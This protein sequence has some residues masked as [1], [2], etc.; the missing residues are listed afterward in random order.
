MTAPQTVILAE[1]IHTL[2]EGRAATALGITDGLITHVGSRQDAA[3]W[4]GPGTEVIDHGGATITPGLVDAHIHPVFGQ[5]VARGIFLGDANTL[6]EAAALVAGAAGGTPEPEV[7]L[8]YGLNQAVFGNAEPH[9]NWLEAAAP[10]RKCYITCFDAHSAMASPAMLRA[11]GVTGTERFDD[12]STV[13]LSA[14]GQPTGFLR[15]FGAMQLIESALPELSLD[16]KVDGVYQLLRGMAAA[17]LTGGEMLDFAD[18]DSLEIF[19]LIERRGEL[20]IKLRIAPWIMASDGLAAIERVRDMQG[21][22]GRRWHV[23]G[24]KLM[25]DGTVDNGTAWLYEPDTEGECTESLYMDP[26][27]YRRNLQQLAQSG[28]TTTTHAIGDQGI[29]FVIQAISELPSNGLAHRIEHLEEINDEDMEALAGSGATVSMQPS[30]CTHFVRAD[31]SDAW[32]RRLGE[33]RAS[34]AFRLRDVKDAGLVLALGSDWPVAPYDPRRI[35]AD[36]QTRRRTEVSGSDS[37][38]PRHKLTAR[39]ALEGYTVNV[40]ASSGIEGGRLAPGAPADLTVFA[41]DPLAISPEELCDVP[42]VATYIE[43]Q[44]VDTAAQLPSARV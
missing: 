34:F 9:G 31:G 8:G 22:Q 40:Y 43:G 6:E 13:A 17:G 3:A 28:V 25:I 36:A 20:P 39:E 11:A 18:P 41:S 35:M 19:R 30:H 42:V 14:D 1:T 16:E 23:R 15:E 10:G 12:G 26:E 5:Q 29:G 33:H 27:Q 2:A 24:V 21:S 38:Q 32:S 4:A 44:K 7:V 37:V